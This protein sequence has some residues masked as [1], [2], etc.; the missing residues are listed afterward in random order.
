MFLPLS[1]YILSVDA[2]SKD[3][4][5]LVNVFRILAVAIIFVPF[6]SAYRGFYQGLRE[7]VFLFVM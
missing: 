2:T 4:Q 6:L 3:I 1:K 7:L 5:T